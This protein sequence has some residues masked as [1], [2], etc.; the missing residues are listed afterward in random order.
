MPKASKASASQSFAV[1]GYKGHL[2]A[3]VVG[4]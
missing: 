4:L 2:P 3:V 1:E